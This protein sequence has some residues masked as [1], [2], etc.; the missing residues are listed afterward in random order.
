MGT[1]PSVGAGELGAWM[2]CENPA[3]AG[4]LTRGREEEGVL[5]VG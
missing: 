2:G 5:G 3:N 1:S 4:L